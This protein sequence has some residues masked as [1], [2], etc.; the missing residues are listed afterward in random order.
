MRERGW[1]GGGGREHTHLS[2]SLSVTT[3]KSLSIS[4]F[5]PLM[6]FSLLSH[7]GAAITV[8]D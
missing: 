6:I 3:V 8:T 2:A 4:P 1:R 5:S 7:N